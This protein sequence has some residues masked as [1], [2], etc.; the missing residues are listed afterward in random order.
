MN[1]RGVVLG[2]VLLPGPVFSAHIHPPLQ[3][4]AQV[5]ACLAL[6]LSLPLCCLSDRAGLGTSASFT[7]TRGQEPPREMLGFLRLM[8][9]SGGCVCVAQTYDV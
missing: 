5:T 3:R 4:S 7:I 2:T 1:L 8:Q 6:C 9:L